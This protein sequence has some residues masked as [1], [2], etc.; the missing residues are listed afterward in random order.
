MWIYKYVVNYKNISVHELTIKTVYICRIFEN[1]CCECSEK[2][3]TWTAFIFKNANKDICTWQITTILI[4]KR[5][6]VEAK[7]F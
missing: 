1:K 6:K 3:K 5:L 2:I 7:I 4:L